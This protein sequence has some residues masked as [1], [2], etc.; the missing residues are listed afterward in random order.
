M[1]H[2]DGSH[3][4]LEERGYGVPALLKNFQGYNTP[5]NHRHRKRSHTNLSREMLVTHSQT[6]FSLLTK[7]FWS[8]PAW[9]DMKKATETIQ[10][11]YEYKPDKAWIG[12]DSALLQRNKTKFGNNVLWR[13]N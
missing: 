1:W 12:D 11:D 3:S 8:K 9:Q 10:K 13:H 2:I 4:T 5:Q 6:L 7:D